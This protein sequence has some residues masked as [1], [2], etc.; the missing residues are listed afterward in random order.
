[1]Q[2]IGHDSELLP[3]ETRA[4]VVLVALLQGLL[5]YIAQT[6]R[7]NGWWPFDALGGQVC[8]YT[9]V[10]SVPTM[11]SL[12]VRRL[13]DARFWQHVALVGSIVSLLAAWATWSATGAPGLDSGAV[14]RP[15]GFTTALALFVA[16]PYLQCRLQHGR[17]Q[18]PY[19]ELF[20][21]AWQNALTLALTLLFVGICWAVLA[22]WASLFA[23][24]RI[25]F[26]KE[27]FRTEAFVYLATG[28]MAGLGILIG[29]TQQR[30]VQVARQILFAIFKGLLPLL[31]AI[32]L[33]FMASLPFTGL[34]PLWNTRSAASLLMSVII[35]LVLFVNAVYQDGDDASPYPIWL[36]RIVDAS[37][38]LLPIYAGLALYA[39]WLRIDQYGW[40]AD[41]LWVLLLALLLTGY[42]LGYAMAA[43]HRHGPWLQSLRRV[44]I[45]SSLAAITI[46]VLANSP[47]LDP[48]RIAIASQLQ[49]LHD[50]RIAIDTFDFEHLRFDSGRRGYRAALALRG[51][52]MIANSPQRLAD[53]D[54][55][56][57]RRL[58]RQQRFGRSRNEQE[59]RRTAVK[60]TAAA[61]ALIQPAVGASSPDE[62]WLQ[63]LI[64]GRLQAGECLQTDSDCVLLTPDLDGDGAPERLLC[65][66][67][68]PWGVQC[69]LHTQRESAWTQAGQLQWPDTASVLAGP[70]RRGEL[71]VRRQRWPELELGGRRARID[72]SPPGR[73]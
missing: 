4:F 2:D 12:S 26:F 39:L 64:D 65:D 32:A 57:D 46:A 13:D 47:V 5:L 71:R 33:L 31:A 52:P 50:G 55:R 25:D 51:D 48:H 15:Y 18:A 34:E 62:A 73:R 1:M 30:P 49:R 3:R 22:L 38:V 9:L 35:A 28:T 69:Q 54:R 23:L 72:A 70:L 45:A 17:W 63:A 58:K 59:L 29:R 60:S 53:L 8:W 24:I 56:L 40:T 20:E 10:L 37:L 61:R 68:Q 36:R 11:M 14:L 41:R 66:L 27:L 67:G 21:H 43:L 19:P 42:A 44:N 16:L 7:E 6:G